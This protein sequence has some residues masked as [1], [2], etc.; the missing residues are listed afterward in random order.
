MRF[1]GLRDTPDPRFQA[2]SAYPARGERPIRDSNPCQARRL[3]L[4]LF[5]GN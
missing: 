3:F 4:S 5:D 2:V 1:E